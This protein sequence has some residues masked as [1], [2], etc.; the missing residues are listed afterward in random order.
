MRLKPL[1]SKGHKRL[2]EIKNGAIL[3]P[4]LNAQ[5]LGS[6]IDKII[7]MSWS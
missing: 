1:C 2:T 4:G 7:R 6:C 5:L 3:V